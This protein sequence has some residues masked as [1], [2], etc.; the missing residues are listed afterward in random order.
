MQFDVFISYSSKNAAAA[1]AVCSAL[2]AANVRCWMAPRDILPGADWAASIMEAVANSR[3]MVLVFSSHANASAQVRREV[4]QAFEHEI[5]VL[6]IRIE[7]VAPN[8]S[9]SFYM[10]S[11]HWLDAVTEPL[12][13][14]LAVLTQSV[15]RLMPDRAVQREADP[16]ATPTRPLPGNTSDDRPLASQTGANLAAAAPPTFVS[17]EWNEFLQETLAKRVAGSADPEKSHRATADRPTDSDPS[18]WN[19]FIFLSLCFLFITTGLFIDSLVHFDYPG[20]G[21]SVLTKYA[22]A[23]IL[24]LATTAYTIVRRVKG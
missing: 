7:N 3:I 17:P 18:V 11:V 22:I 16:P 2:E 9:L 13:Q 4:R 10:G 15:S 19:A 20:F 24:N 12:Q 21:A 14:H 8:S 6:P 23:W 1:Q 5:P